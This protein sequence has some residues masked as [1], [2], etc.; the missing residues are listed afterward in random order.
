MN[1]SSLVTRQQ[2]PQSLAHQGGDAQGPSQAEEAEEG[3]L[4]GRRGQPCHSS[5]HGQSQRKT[6]GNVL[7]TNFTNMELT[8]RKVAFFLFF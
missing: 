5:P 1:I 7:L 3:K 4:P 8:R 6:I 2:V